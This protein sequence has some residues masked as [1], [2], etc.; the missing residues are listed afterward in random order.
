MS[1]QSAANVAYENR[2]AS[3]RED[4]TSPLW[5]LRAAQILLD[6][7]QLRAGD[8]GGAIADELAWHSDLGA[9]LIGKG[10][11]RPHDFYHALAEAQELPFVDLLEEPPDPDLLF[12]EDRANYSALKLIPW[13]LVEGHWL[14]ATVDTGEAQRQWAERR[15]GDDFQLRHHLALRHLLGAARAF[16]RP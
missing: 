4:A 5:H 7:G 10:L 14:I 15:F 9:V 3:P 2:N 16:P 8:F 12:A 6:R 1:A 13:R 11:V